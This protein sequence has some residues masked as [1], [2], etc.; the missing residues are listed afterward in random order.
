MASFLHSQGFYWDI[1]LLLADLNKF[2]LAISHKS[3]P[4]NNLANLKILLG[5]C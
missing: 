1:K 3:E 2:W 4:F 5:V